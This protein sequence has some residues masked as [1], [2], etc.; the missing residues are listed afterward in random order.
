MQAKSLPQIGYKRSLTA[1]GI[2]S[3]KPTVLIVDSSSGPQTV[4]DTVRSLGVK[5]LEIKEPKNIDDIKSEVLILEKYFNKTSYNII[6]KIDDLTFQ[7]K[8]SQ[9]QKKPVIIFISRHGD[10]AEFASGRGMVQ[11]EIIHLAGGVNAVTFS[12]TKSMNL[13]AMA[14]LQADYIIDLFH[15]LLT[16]KK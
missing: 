11:E 8:V 9:S 3:L 4:I 7:I 10:V 14:S 2:L 16:S 5:I 1:E 13:E 15:N 12:G 6:Q